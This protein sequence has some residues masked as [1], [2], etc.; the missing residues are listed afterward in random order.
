MTG[1]VVE[2]IVGREDRLHK[3]RMKLGSRTGGEMQL[4]QAKESHFILRSKQQR[5]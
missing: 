4:G 2:N 3:G 5:A 1:I